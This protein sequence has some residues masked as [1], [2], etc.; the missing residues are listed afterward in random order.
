MQ[1]GEGGQRLLLSL[2]SPVGVL[3]DRQSFKI[4]LGEASKMEQG[5]PVSRVFCGGWCH[6]PLPQNI[7]HMGLSSPQ[8]LLICHSFCYV[9]KILCRW[10]HMI[11]GH[12]VLVVAEIK[13]C[14]DSRGFFLQHFSFL[15]FLIVSC[16]IKWTAF[17]KGQCNNMKSSI[18]L[19]LKSYL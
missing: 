12:S 9:P 4:L 7:L 2:A 8:G 14:L 3:K 16:S 5:Q 11:N 13:A 10:E 15:F 17:I 1:S 19:F 6:H 18:I